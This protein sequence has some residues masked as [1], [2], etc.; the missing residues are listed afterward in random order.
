MPH[1]GK[2]ATLEGE[3]CAT[4]CTTPFR[5]S[6][7]QRQQSPTNWT[8]TDRR[9]S[10]GGLLRVKRVCRPLSSPAGADNAL[11]C[12]RSREA[13]RWWLIIDEQKTGADFVETAPGQLRWYAAPRQSHA[14]ANDGTDARLRPRSAPLRLAHA[15]ALLGQPTIART[16]PPER[17]QRP[18]RARPATRGECRRPPIPGQNQAGQPGWRSWQRRRRATQP[19][20]AG[21]PWPDLPGCATA[22]RGARA[23][24]RASRLDA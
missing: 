12:L 8:V 1:A 17:D 13:A 21:D 18:S 9:Y 4:S 24:S 11:G 15:A 3:R 14:P 20:R 22:A 7:D 16:R 6:P 19:S 10:G 5:E 2:P 23:P